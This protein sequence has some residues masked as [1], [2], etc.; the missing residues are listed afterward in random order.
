[1]SHYINELKKFLRITA[2]IL[3]VFNAGLI[4]GFLILATFGAINTQPLLVIGGLTLTIL[5][6]YITTIMKTQNGKT[7]FER[8]MG[9]DL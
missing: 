8:L 5:I 4:S 9:E 3:I 6:L 7:I 2:L 1:M